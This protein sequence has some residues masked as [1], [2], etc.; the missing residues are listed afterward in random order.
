MGAS[1]HRGSSLPPTTTAVPPYKPVKLD[2]KTTGEFVAGLLEVL[3]MHATWKP[4]EELVKLNGIPLLCQIVSIASEWNYTGRN[5]TIC[6]ALDVLQFA[7]IIPKV[8]LELCDPV[9]LPEEHAVAIR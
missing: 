6:N 1:P 5:E 3:P 2:Q 7:S 9:K 4:V 8:P